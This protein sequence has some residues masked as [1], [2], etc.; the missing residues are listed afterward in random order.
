MPGDVLFEPDFFQALQRNG[1]IE[2]VVAGGRV[3]VADAQKADFRRLVGGH[4]EFPTR[5][6]ARAK[7]DLQLIALNFDSQNL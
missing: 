1:K 5:R 2:D 3:V 7:R 6:L 4:K